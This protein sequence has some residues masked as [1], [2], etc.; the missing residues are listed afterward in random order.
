MHIKVKNKEDNMKKFAALFLALVMCLSL[1][2]CGETQTA[3]PETA[4][5][6]ATGTSDPEALPT[7]DE[8]DLL[9]G[10]ATG[11]WYTVG[12]GI[13]DKFNENFEGFPMTC[14]PGPG[15]VGNIG[16]ISSGD[17]EIGMS[18]GP[19]L[20][21]AVAGNAPYDQAYEN[22][23][24]IA[25]LQPTVIQPLTTLDID[26]FDD[27]ILGKMK[28]TVGLYP[29]G[30]GS[31]TAIENI[32]K[33]YGL[34]GIDAIQDW[35]ATPYYADG[36][37]LADAWADRHIDVQM[38]MLNVPASTVTE[39]L[40]SRTDGKLFSLG[41]DVIKELCDN[42]GFA[43][44]TIAAGTYNGQDEDIKTVGLPI[45]LFCRDDAD[46]DLIYTF[47][48]TLY[49]NKDYFLGV[50]SSFAEFEPETMNVGTAITLHPGA[51]KFYKEMGMM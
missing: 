33:A 14:I 8:L 15:S 36:A 32:F 38:P 28:A 11:S 48:K 21:A 51:E 19:F 17:S 1:A 3:A 42:Y 22:L 43:E 34:S 39:A 9:S 10:S 18:Y 47:T 6:E 23:R 20:I 31:T 37:S 45:V 30:N 29:V 41:D 50:H 25:A 13:A 24:A 35:G 49:E 16:V 46:E 7:I 26:S 44:Y 2:A 12:A 4:T 27:I 40:V 5:P